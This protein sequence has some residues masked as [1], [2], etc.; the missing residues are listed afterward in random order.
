MCDIRS[1]TK[2]DAAYP[3][4]FRELKAMPDKLYYRGSLPDDRPAVAIVGSRKC[5][6]YGRQQACYFAD[7][8]ARSGVAIISGMAFGV[9]SAAQRAALAAG[10][11][12]FAVLGC[13]VDICYPWPSRDLYND[14][15]RAGGILSE[16]EPGTKPEG[17]HFPVRNRL[18]SALSDIVVVIEA[19]P[20]SGSLITVDFALEQGRSV[21]A[22]PGRVTDAYSEGC[23]ALIAQGASVALSPEVI[24]DEL[25]KQRLL[26]KAA[27]PEEP[28]FL[29]LAPAAK[30]ILKELSD[31]PLP[32]DAL[33]T[34]TALDPAEAAAALT[35]LM[36]AGHAEE[37][38]PHAYV[39]ALAPPVSG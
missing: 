25:K 19:R 12:S 8:L 29:P 35:E 7:T 4:R 14:L 1:V 31:D 17:W 38:A 30:Q 24:L 3:S 20:N 6:P 32:L 11:L 21:Y 10:G 33:L 39:R 23:N 28:V 16:F 22:L 26:E 37:C 27:A 15:L 13:G 5:T 34:A 2:A 18:I 9:D 36:L